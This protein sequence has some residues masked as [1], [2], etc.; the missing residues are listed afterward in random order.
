MACLSRV[1]NELRIKQALIDTQGEELSKIQLEFTEKFKEVEQNNEEK[2]KKIM[3]GLNQKV[4]QMKKKSLRFDLL[5]SYHSCYNSLLETL[6]WASLWKRFE[7]F[8]W[9][10][11]TLLRA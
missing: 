5:D 9:E 7:K 6:F 10:F 8:V 2:F 3:D 1:A 11:C 4:L